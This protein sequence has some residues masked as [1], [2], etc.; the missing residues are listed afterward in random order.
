LVVALETVQT[1]CFQALVMV[2]L[3]SME[4]TF[5]VHAVFCESIINSTARGE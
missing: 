4:Q 3:A 1:R 5:F 2:L